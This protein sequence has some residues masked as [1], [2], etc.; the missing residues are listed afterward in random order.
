MTNLEKLLL[1]I[2]IIFIVGPII[3][4]IGQIIY[5]STVPCNNLIERYG[6][7]S[8]VMITGASRGQG[9]F[10]AYEFAKRKFNLILIGSTRTNS[11]AEYIRN[12]YKVNVIV[13]IKDFSNSLNDNWLSEIED[14]FNNYDISVLINNVGN[15][16]ASDPSH[17][18]SD[19]KIRSSLITGSYPQIKLTN[20]ALKYMI[21]R[22]KNKSEYKC[23]II[24]NTAQCIHPT[25]L[26]SQ[27]YQTGEISVP[28]LSVYEATNAFGYYH[29]N[30]L[31]KEYKNYN[32]DMLNIMPGAVI[33]EN[34]E[35]LKDI[36]FA[37]DAK[38]FAKN[39][40]RL[41][42]NW[43]GAT[44]AYWGHDISSLL[45]GLAPWAKE[46]ILN[47]VGLTLAQSLKEIN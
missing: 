3:S 29:A 6:N 5:K 32:I 21:E 45:I 36:P 23:G 7:D 12:N 18:Q 2:I 31:I 33:T 26:L 38:T 25:F 47:K 8:Y 14:A 10:L 39:I 34:T 43:H 30:S 37:I 28:Y 46:K 42:G 19:E 41:L 44:C 16:S 9:Q 15:R 13:I 1:I 4:F 22:L 17:L 24:F 35:F 40:I 27:Y 20:L 11:T